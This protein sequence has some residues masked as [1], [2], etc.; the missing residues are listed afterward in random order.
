MRTLL[1][2]EEKVL[3]FVGAL[4]L[5]CATLVGVAWT[6]VVVVGAARLIWWWV[7]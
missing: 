6:A 3:C 7:S 2:L 4:A 1:S 5:A